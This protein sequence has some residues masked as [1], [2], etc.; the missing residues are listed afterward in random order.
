MPQPHLRSRSKKRYK[1][2][3]PGGKSQTHYKKEIMKTPK[4]CVCGNP[5]AGTSHLSTVE[6]RKL[7]RSKRKVERP[8]GGQLCHNCIKKAL[9]QTARNI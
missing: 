4:C 7:N 8:Y 5:I 9:K 6:T 2:K 1:T 3:S